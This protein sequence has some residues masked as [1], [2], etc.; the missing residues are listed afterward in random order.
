MTI[1]EQMQLHIKTVREVYPGCF[2][3]TD[4]FA[5]N[6]KYGR[7][8]LHFMVYKRFCKSYPLPISKSFNSE[9][10]AWEDAFNNLKSK[11]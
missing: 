2:C 1:Q 10:E 3:Q 7:I 4:L 11:V 6:L 5:L 9:I 8:E